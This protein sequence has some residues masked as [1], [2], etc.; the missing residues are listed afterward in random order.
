MSQVLI[1]IVDDEEPVRDATKSLV[2]S[3]GY[4]ASAF[5]SADDFL[6]SEQVDIVPYHRC[7]N[8]GAERP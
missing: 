4:H 3:L 5:G 6:K 2:R 1:A 8:A 7:A